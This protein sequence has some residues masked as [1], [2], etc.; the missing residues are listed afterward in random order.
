MTAPAS[1]ARRAWLRALAAIA[2]LAAGVA[3]AQDPRA[4]TVQQT[5][6]AWLAL[7]DRLDATA[8]FAAA[9]EK[10]RAPITADAWADAL[11]KAR[12]PLG[13]VIQRAV[14]ETAFDRAAAPD[15]G[16]E[17][18]IAVILFRTAFAHKTASSESVTLALDAD[19]TWR[20]IGYFIR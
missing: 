1:V 15:G 19:G 14:A 17:V 13:A 20:V 12:A 10:F 6:R 2:C 3:S 8:S 5:A 9:G 4:I 16:P 18:D 7:V 11:E